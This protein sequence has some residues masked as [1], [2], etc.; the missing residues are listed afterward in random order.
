MSQ[1]ILMEKTI[2]VINSLYE[3]ATVTESLKKHG[4]SSCAFYSRLNK[5]LEL[6]RSYAL[7]QEARAELMVD[8]ILDI[9]DNDEDANRARNKI[10]ARQWIASKQ[11]PKKYGDRIEL[12]HTVTADIKGVLASFDIRTLPMRDLNETPIIQVIDTPQLIAS[13]VTGSK[14]VDASNENECVPVSVPDTKD[15]IFS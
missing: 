14:P 4:I 1:D 9:A 10:Q 5:D 13:E 12:N 3:G 6:E 7:A 8:Q 11:R 2:A 15:D